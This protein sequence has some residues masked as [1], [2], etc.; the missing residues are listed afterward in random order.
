M[1][2]LTRDVRYALRQLRSNPGFTLVALLTLGLGIGANTAMFSVVD[3][4]LLRPLPFREPKQLVAVRTTEPG[5]RD[6]IGVSYPAFL[7]WRNR[8][9]VFEGLSAFREDDFTLTGKGEAAHL[10]GGVVSANTFSL[11]GVSPLLGRNFLPDEDQPLSTGLP[12]ILSDHLWRDRFASDPGILGQTL[13]I[14]SQ[15]FT[16]VGVMPAGFQFPVQANGIDFW[17][18]LALD[19]RPMNG[20]PPLSSQRGVSY[21]DV[22]ARL[23]PYILLSQAQSEMSAIQDSINRQYPENRPKGIAIVPEIDD[24]VGSARSGLLILLGAVG[25][26]LL[27]A[28]A[29]ISNLFLAKALTRQREITVRRA[30]GATRW[31]LVRQ[32]TMES[33][34]LAGAGAAVGLVFAVWSIR[35][36]TRLSPA[37]LPRILDSGLNLRV[38]GFT[39]A[40]AVLTSVLFGLVPAIHATSAGLA[41]SLNEVGRSG[42]ETRGRR[43]LSNSFVIAQSALAVVLLAGAGL[44]SRTLVGLGKVDPGFAKDHVIT[45]GLDLP[46]RY[47]HVQRVQFY[48]Q[49]L[50]QIRNLPGVQSASAAFP[51]PLSA[52]DVKTSFDVEGQ[53]RKESARPVTTL[54]VVD[55]DYFH[56]LGIPLLRG[57]A[58]DAH[59][60]DPQATP[61]VV[62][63]EDLAK[64][65]FPGVD[66]I[67]KRI[68][69]NISSGN[70]AAPMRRV[71]GVVGDVKAEGL[72][73]PAIPE[74]Y[75]PYAQLPFAPMSVLVRTVL[76]PEGM[77]PTLT[78]QVQSLDKDLPLLNVK[79]LEQYVDDSI[80]GTKFEAILL[81][82]FAGLAFLLT[83]IGLFG[84]ISYTTVRRTREL[85]IRLA[86]GAERREIVGL[87]VTS[88]LWLAGLGTAIGLAAA[89]LLSR[90]MASLLYGIS[91]TDP[92]TFA[93]VAIALVGTAA[94][95]SYIP[96]RRAARIDP[97][98]ALRYE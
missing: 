66:P 77:V 80:A 39:A 86:L 94:L 25:F 68:Q 53:P 97:M 73:A 35:L 88:G 37:E 14:S 32:L 27:I 49:L 41:S 36:L 7:D 72:S 11:L 76:G 52:D 23:K 21:L 46:S 98:A 22:L 84:V 57:R 79:P 17:T 16:I 62:I 92:L 60:D 6:D 8:N 67:G 44:L 55:N 70:A 61:V 30:L 18:T 50:A 81:G 91:A 40:T 12:V 31:S 82:I 33:L 64:Q 74:S 1:S 71:V 47:G 54:H 43:R 58:F 24:V 9:H 34:L 19:A 26:V 63:S 95:A 28:C 3:A 42:T 93:V 83:A 96:A 51:L 89:L 69:P 48:Q 45:F 20:G 85:G 75:V 2:K 13:T 5:R 10:F 59:D 56:A 65:V 29:N 90:F 38:L 15:V 78:K 87:V 4:V